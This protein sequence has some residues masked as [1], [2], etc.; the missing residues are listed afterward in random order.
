[1][2]NINDPPEIL[3]TDIKIIF[4]DRVYHVKYIAID[5]DQSDYI[6]KWELKTNASWLSLDVQSGILEGVPRNNDVG[7][8]YVNISSYDTNNSS[9]FHNFTLIVMNTAPNI[10]TTNIIR[11]NEEEKYYIDYSS[12]DDKQ[13]I[14]TWFLK[15][16]ASWLTINPLTGV[17]SGTPDDKDIGQFWINISVNDGNG[18]TNWTN[19]T[20]IVYNMNEYPIITSKPI[21]DAYVDKDYYYSISVSDEDSNDDLQFFLIKCPFGMTINRSIGTIHWIP[22]QGQ[23]GKNDIIIKVTDS[24]FEVFQY[25]NITVHPH[26][27]VIIQQ[28]LNGQLIHGKLLIKGYVKGPNNSTVEIN[29]DNNSWTKVNGNNTWAYQIDTHLL[30]N[31]NHTI[32]VRAKWDNYQSEATDIKI[33]VKNTTIIDNNIE[34]L[35]IFIILFLVFISCIII[36]FHMSYSKIKMKNNR[37]KVSLQRQKRRRRKK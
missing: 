2:L 23:E 26:L 14:I 29:I 27:I 24:L 33:I 10:L 19:F 8:F 12:D 1:V 9:S 34:L 28:P 21:I 30:K 17:L 13:G 4:E 37:K 36:I 5:I 22:I 31:G 20:L 25:Y 18:G 7:S 15:T 16:N 6:T 11:A 3:T 32:S 35:F